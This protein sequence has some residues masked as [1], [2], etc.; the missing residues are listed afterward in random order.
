[1][2][3]AGT[4]SPKISEFGEILQANIWIC[5]MKYVFHLNNFLMNVAHK[6]LGLTVEGLKELLDISQIGCQKLP[7]V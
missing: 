2:V 6:H 5:Y 4:G 1:M 7:Q 3:H